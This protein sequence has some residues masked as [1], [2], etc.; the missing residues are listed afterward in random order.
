MARLVASFFGTG[1]ILRRLRDDDTGSGTVG[2]LFALLLALALYPVGWWAQAIVFGVVVVA[3]LISTRQFAASEGDPSWVVIDEAAGSL[4]ATVGLA[5]GAAVVGWLVFR[6]AD[7]F[8]GV[9]PGVAP[10]ERLGGSL[11]ITADDVVA[12]LYGLA[13]GWLF[14][15]LT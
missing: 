12:G 15:T 3:S 14:Q 8:K 11:G 2:G 10:A 5:P 6:V 1:L 13:A 7:I 4:L 9:F